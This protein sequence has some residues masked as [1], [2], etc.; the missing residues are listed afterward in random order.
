M[1][2]R[3]MGGRGDYPPMGSS[4]L[5]PS[6]LGGAPRRVRFIRAVAAAAAVVPEAVEMWATRGLAVALA[7]SVLP[8]SRALRPGDCEG[9][10]GEGA[11]W[12]GA[13]G[14]E[15]NGTERAGAHPGAVRWRKGLGIITRT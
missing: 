7:L 3:H 11:G 10:W 12:G 4:G 15:P 5:C 1:R 13:N 2:M 8:D 14:A 6:P 9:A